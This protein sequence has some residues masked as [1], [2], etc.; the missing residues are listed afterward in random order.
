MI[1]MI[2]KDFFESL[3]KG[4]K[5]DIELR[6]LPSRTTLFTRD[7]EEIE[8]FCQKRKDENQYFGVG[9][10]EG[11]RGT[12]EHVREIPALFVDIDFHGGS[13][14][15]REASE[16]LSSFTHKPSAVIHSGGGFHAYWFLAKPFTPA[17]DIEPYLKGLCKNLEGDL[18]A[19]ECAR[20]LR[21]PGT[22][23]QKYPR[24]VEIVEL[25]PDRRYEI[26]DFAA[27]VVTGDSYRQTLEY[28]DMRGSRK[29]P[30][31]IYESAP[32]KP[33]I[34]AML[35]QN[36]D[37]VAHLSRNAIS[38]AI[39]SELMRLGW[40]E[41]KIAG[42]ILGWNENNIKPINENKLRENLAYTLQQDY[43]YSCRHDLLKQ[44]CPFASKTLCPYGK[45][46]AKAKYFNNRSFL[47]YG[48]QIILKNA[49]KDVYYIGLPEL[50]RRKGVGPG[51][52]IFA[53]EREIAQWSGVSLKSVTPALRELEK[54]G[55]I[56]FTIGT[57]RVWERKATEI[58]RTLPIPKPSVN[59]EEKIP[60]EREKSKHIETVWDK[61]SM[62][63]GIN[64]Y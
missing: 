62:E 20:I 34:D 30:A 48:W 7:V 19:A 22:V 15:G 47:Q 5:H 12:K 16:R 33:C 14:A 21:I 54:Y 4:T 27:M 59:G 42:T 17:I 31:V 61:T 63:G 49:P 43:G 39:I 64:A 29:K 23:N 10:R 60:G 13:D 9:T 18:K 3:F 25:D 57:P 58:R 32:M 44:F 55:L 41:R 1:F 36:F 6:A 50:E 28:A 51:G 35:R 38:V 40:E 8:S 46:M 53:N 24:S 52:T 26:E 45:E 56:T 37:K 11:K 2:R